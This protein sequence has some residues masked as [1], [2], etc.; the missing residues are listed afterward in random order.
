MT[1]AKAELYESLRAFIHDGQS[2]DPVVR[3]AQS[4]QALLAARDSR[5]EQARVRMDQSRR[6][7]A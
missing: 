5:D 2:S 3:A 6:T 4:L 1:E 7:A